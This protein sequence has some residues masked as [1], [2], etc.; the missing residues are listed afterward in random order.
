MTIRLIVKRWLDSM[1]CLLRFDSRFLLSL[2]GLVAVGVVWWQDRQQL[3]QRINTLERRLNPSPS[4]YWGGSWGI[5]QVVGPPNTS[6]AGDIPTA[7]ASATPDGQPEWLDLRYARAVVPSQV[8]VH[9]NY[10]P[11]AVTKITAFDSSG[12]EFIVWQGNDPTPTSAPSGVSNFQLKN[13]PK[14]NR[15]KLYLASDKVPGW[16]EI[17]A[18]GLRYGWL[19]GVLWVQHAAASSTYGQGNP[20]RALKGVYN[21]TVLDLQ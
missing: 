5:E 14:T 13:C 4:I 15:I 18:V 11:G 6:K 12:R 1:R 3:E 9:E 20:G 16:N 10:N 8:E 2:T 7:W 17:D 21:G 19:G